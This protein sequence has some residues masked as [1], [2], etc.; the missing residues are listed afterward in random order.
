MAEYKVLMV[1]ESGAATLFLSASGLP[2][3]KLQAALNENAADG[4]ELAFQ[5]VER[6][7]FLLFW[8]RDAV[9]LTLVRRRP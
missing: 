9:I 4:W 6:R 3:K 2:L 1:Q 8:S 7:R 5:V